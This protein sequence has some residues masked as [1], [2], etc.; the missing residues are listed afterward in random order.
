[1]ADNSCECRA[2]ILELVILVPFN[3]FLI[4]LDG[5]GRSL[6]ITHLPGER[7]GE[8]KRYKKEITHFD[9]LEFKDIC[10]KRPIVREYWQNCV[11]Y[12]DGYVSR[13][14]YVGGDREKFYEY[15]VC[16]EMGVQWKSRLSWIFEAISNKTKYPENKEFFGR[17]SHKLKKL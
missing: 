1:M 14:I 12:D 6:Y 17:L 10:F 16:G 2:I 7:I 9:E 5:Q 3:S 13:I 15:F 8:I 11:D 4:V